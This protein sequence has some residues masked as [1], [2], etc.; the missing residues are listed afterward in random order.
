MRDQAIEF[1]AGG[2]SKQAVAQTLGC[3][4]PQIDAWLKEPEVIASLT[5]RAKELQSERIDKRYTDLEEA[6]LKQLKTDLTMM[7]ASSLCRILETVAR[8]RI[9]AKLPAGHYTNPTVGASITLVLPATGAEV[10]V[11]SKN[12]VIAIGGRN[13][14]AMPVSGV[15]RLFEQIEHNLNDMKGDCDE[16]QVANAA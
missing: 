16:S 1:L 12:Q 5:T 9:A 10:I 2:F 11:D 14:G 6:T 13:M 7:D 15:Q 8:N 3:S 4:E